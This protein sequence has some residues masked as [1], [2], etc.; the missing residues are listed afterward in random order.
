MTLQD[1][2]YKIM[3]RRSQYAEDIVEGRCASFEVYREKTA[4]IRTLDEVLDMMREE[5]K[6]DRPQA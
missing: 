1:L 4:A 2:V 3:E 6:S 5:K